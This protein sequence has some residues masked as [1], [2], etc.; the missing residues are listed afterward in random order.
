L[1]RD[2]KGPYLLKAD[3]QGAELQVLTGATRTMQETEI[4]ILEVSLMA[5]M[6]GG[7]ELLDI[8]SRMKDLGFVAY[9]LFG[10]HYRPLDNAL[11]QVDM[12][13]VPQHSPLRKS[14]AYATAE[15]RQA[16]NQRQ[17]ENFS[18]LRRQLW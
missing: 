13:F 18:R 9:D 16:W 4:I 10:L 11:C 6:I 8:V 14:R 2:L 17:S 15:Q 1:E 12:V 3:V 5:A 7:P